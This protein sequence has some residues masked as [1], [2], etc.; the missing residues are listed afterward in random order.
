MAAVFAGSPQL[1]GTVKLCSGWTVTSLPLFSDIHL[2]RSSEDVSSPTA[3]MAATQ[4]L[5]DSTAGKQATGSNPLC[6]IKVSAEYTVLL[7]LS[8]V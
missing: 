2:L 5:D 7:L 1:L 6:W 4:W 8:L 3:R